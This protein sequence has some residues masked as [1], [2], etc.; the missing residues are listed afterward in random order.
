MKATSRH[1]IYQQIDIIQ[2]WKREKLAG[3]QNF[4]ASV[5]PF[6]F[7]ENVNDDFCQ[8]DCMLSNPSGQLVEDCEKNNIIK[9]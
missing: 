2:R 3:D 7:Q 8:T 1:T 4:P 5:F 9:N 6:V